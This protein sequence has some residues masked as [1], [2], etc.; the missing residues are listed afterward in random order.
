MGGEGSE[1]GVGVSSD[2]G[3][4]G[5]GDSSDSDESLRALKAHLEHACDLNFTGGL[6]NLEAKKLAHVTLRHR[7]VTAYLD[8][9]FAREE[10]QQQG[11]G[12]EVMEDDSRE[13]KERVEGVG[14]GAGQ[15]TVVTTAAQRQR[16]EDRLV[17]EFLIQDSLRQLS[18]EL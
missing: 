18:I 15:S 1:D 5:G 7:L 2:D 14:A 10:E 12:Q 3:G 9:Y 17:V 6:G 8:H 13:T 11:Q 4:G 16:A